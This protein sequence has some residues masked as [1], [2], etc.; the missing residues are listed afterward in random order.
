MGAMWLIGMVLYGIGARQIGHL[1]PSIGWSIMMSLVVIVANLWG[2]LT[3][4]WKG[5]G[6]KP[7]RIMMLGLVILVIAIFV[8]GAGNRV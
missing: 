4:E 2:I 8:I 6:E 3:G 7:A 1:G 5:T